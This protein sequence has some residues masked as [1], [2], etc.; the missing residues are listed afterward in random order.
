MHVRS[1][2]YCDLVAC[3]FVTYNI[4]MPRNLA[5]TT[6]TKLLKTLRSEIAQAKADVE[7]RLIRTY[8]NTG[9]S[10]EGYLKANP[11]A[12][13][14]ALTRR[15]SKDLNIH[16]RTLQHCHQFSV[17]YPKGA[18]ASPI[19]WSHYRVLL[20]LDSPAQRQRWEKRIIKDK[21]GQRE[22]LALLQ[23]QRQKGGPVGTVRLP[24]PALGELYHYRLI[25]VNNVDPRAGGIMVDC[26]FGICIEPPDCNGKL[27][28]KRIVRCDK[29]EQGY[30]LRFVDARTDAL[31]TYRANVE[32]VVD[33]DTLAVNVDCGFGIW[34]RQK[35]RLKGID[36]PERGTVQGLRA[37]QWVEDQLQ[38]GPEVM[39]ATHKSDKYDRYLADVFCGNVYLNQ[40]LLDEGLAKVYK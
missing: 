32:R 7:Q 13:L 39:I 27:V 25:K 6:Y 9:R 17:V 16:V 29:T 22:L 40:A 33:G 14:A 38:S 31:Y 5:S 26:G 2:P 11:G 36:A 18:P 21:I 28:N 19:S 34:I 12:T 30:S 1:L 10:I 4:V 23:E 37:K 15:L 20:T 24:D 35:L 3:D 8:W